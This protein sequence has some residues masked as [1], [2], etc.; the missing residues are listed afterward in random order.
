[1][2]TIGNNKISKR[3]ADQNTLEILMENIKK[4]NTDQ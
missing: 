4:I 3:V 1:M 2:N